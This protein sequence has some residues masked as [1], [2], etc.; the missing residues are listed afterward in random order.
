MQRIYT[1][2]ALHEGFLP[3]CLPSAGHRPSLGLLSV[4]SGPIALQMVRTLSTPEPLPAPEVAPESQTTPASMHTVASLGAWNVDDVP[5]IETPVTPPEV[6]ALPKGQPGAT[7]WA[8]Q[9][10]GAPRDQLAGAA[11]RLP[12]PAAQLP[13]KPTGLIAPPSEKAPAAPLE[14]A[15]LNA[16]DAAELLADPP[17]LPTIAEEETPAVQPAAESEAAQCC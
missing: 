11:E 12:S 1:C 2:L 5:H 6:P 4:L 14:L 9:D 13:E 7:D 15:S 3:A 16:E 17:A 10:S 8:V